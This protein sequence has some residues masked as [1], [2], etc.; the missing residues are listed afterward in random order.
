MCIRDR[1]SYTFTSN[2]SNA[3]LNVTSIGGYSA[4][5]SIITITVN[6]GVYLWAS[7]TSNNG[8]SL[9]GGTSGD[10]I[11]LVNNGYIMGCGGNGGTYS[12]LP[13][14]GST[15][16][17]LGYNTTVTNNSYIGGG[18]GGGAGYGQSNHYNGGG[19][20]A[21]G[22]NGGSSSYPRASIPT[23]SGGSGGAIGSVGGC[24]QYSCGRGCG[25]C[26]ARGAGGGGRIFP[27]SGGTSP[28]QGG[29]AGGASGATCGDPQA[30]GGS[31]NNAGSTG[32]FG[33]GGGGWG[34]SGGQ[35]QYPSTRNGGSGGN[36]VA[37][38]GYSL[39]QGGSGS[40]WGAVS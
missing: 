31:S 10:S 37:K 30:A 3:S 13:T 20:G 36:S 28:G 27:G 12:V 15:A 8:L 29:G 33:G 17:S 2:T 32:Y 38:N 5:R 19:G 39:S 6:S 40:Y 4:G 18:G 11:T 26:F 1:I 24:G 34:A 14:N 9:S 25:C 16:L 7:S 35:A 21:G 22:G 23:V